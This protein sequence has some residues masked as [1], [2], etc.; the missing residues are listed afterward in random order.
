MNNDVDN[1]DIF[2]EGVD[3]G[4]D[5]S[6]G[7][8]NDV[9]RAVKNIVHVTRKDGSPH[10]VKRDNDVASRPLTGRMKI[11]TSHVISGMPTKEAY[12]AAYNAENSSEGTVVAGGNKLLHDPRI[13]KIISSYLEQ[14]AINILS[15][16]S[17]TRRH[18]LQEL[19][20]HSADN[21]AQLGNRLKALE[22]MGKSFGMFNDK[23]IE[24]PQAIDVQ[25]L[26]KELDSS[27]DNLDKI[28]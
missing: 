24:Q 26:K 15:D 25:V 5:A 2:G 11:F 7:G 13:N 19:L 8:L 10:G 22:L 4:G 16:Q 23:V 20:K 9:E 18:I 28:H 17:V 27:L 21:T 3:S 1:N 12:R 6:D 14:S